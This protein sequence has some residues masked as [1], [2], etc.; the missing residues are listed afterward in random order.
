MDFGSWIRRKGYW[1]VDRVFQHGDVYKYYQE[2]RD[3]YRF[4]T[5]PADVEEKL[6]RLFEHATETTKYYA[7][8]K[9]KNRLADFPIVNKLDYQSK[10]HEF[11]SCKYENDKTCHIEY[12]SGSTGTPLEI[13]YDK[14][15]TRKRYGTSI[16]LNS[17]ADYQIGDKQLYLRIWVDK[18]KKTFIEQKATNV[19]PWDTTNMDDHSLQDICDTILK[20]KVKSI[21][22]YASSLTTLSNYIKDNQIDCSDSKVKSIT[23]CSE[24]MPPYVRKQLED[25]FSCTVSEIYGAEEFG[26]I[27]IQL[28]G[29]DEY[30]I[31][32]SGVFFEVLKMDEDVPA[33]D[34]ELGRLVITDLYNYAFPIIRYENGDTVICRTENCEGKRYKKY[35][36]SIYGR[37]IDVIFGT[38]GG[39][40]SPVLVVN[41]M[42]GIAGI[43][44]WKFIQTGKNTY[45]FVINGDENKVDKNYICDILKED[46]GADAQLSFEFVEEIPVLRSGKRRAIENQYRKEHA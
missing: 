1:I 4:G 17:L 6:K 9:G 46:L 18:I 21:V 45:H 15:K 19:I 31:D 30:Y 33:E 26:T 27:G 32:T 3:A 13:L 29:Q 20:K 2:T 25:Q 42:W 23:P 44:Q 8:Y 12:T 34:G 5:D 10:R 14:N 40:I 36:S 35:F 11:V 38:D 7:P 37:K 22:G 41:R 24:M 28:K 39:A 16:F 43:T